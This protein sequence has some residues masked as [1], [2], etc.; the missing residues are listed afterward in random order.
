MDRTKIL[1]AVFKVFCE[2]ENDH[3]KKGGDFGVTNFFYS[4]ID[5]FA[6]V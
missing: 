5:V 2:G 3:M 6:I 4:A 1:M